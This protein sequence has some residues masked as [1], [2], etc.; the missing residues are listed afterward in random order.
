MIR[1]DFYDLFIK[2]FLIFL[3]LVQIKIH[4]Q[5]SVFSILVN[6]RHFFCDADVWHLI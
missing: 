3:I 5:S 2:I 1:Y 6:Y 4:S